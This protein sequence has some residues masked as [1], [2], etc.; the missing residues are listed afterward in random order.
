MTQE[1]GVFI[2]I[3]AE[4]YHADKNIVGHSALVRMLRSPAHYRHYVTTPHEPT[5][6]LKF[7]TALHTAVLEPDVFEE[8]YVVQPKFDRRTKDGKALAEQWELANAEKVAIE[9]DKK[10][11]LQGM[12]SA[13]ARHL[14]AAKLLRNGWTEKSL[15]WVDPDTG[16]MCGIRPDLLAVDNLGRIIAT[17]DLKSTLDAGKDKFAKSMANYGYDVQAAFYTDGIAQ[18]IG[19]EVPFYFLAAESE[20]PH[21]VGLYKT[22]PK[23]LEAGRAKVRM[24]LQ[25]MQWCRENDTWPSYQP[26]GEEE[27]IEIPHWATKMDL[28]GE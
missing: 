27:E 25:L 23:T 10:V 9:E 12:Q 24:G 13:I 26:F 17:V 11:C 3:P 4:E 16:I 18:A 6:A 1:L 5:P 22:G 8:T 20:A 21:G 19:Y 28:D 15:F 7:G 2:D 14:G